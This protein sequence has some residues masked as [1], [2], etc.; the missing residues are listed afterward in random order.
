MSIKGNTSRIK[1]EWLWRPTFHELKNNCVWKTAHNDLKI[2][3]YESQH[4]KNYKLLSIKANISWTKNNCVW[5][6]TL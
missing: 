5:K 3:E 4:F 6:P 2:I 1:N